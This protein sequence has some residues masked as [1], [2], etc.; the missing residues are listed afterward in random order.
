MVEFPLIRKGRG[1]ATYHTHPD[2]PRLPD[3]E[4]REGFKGDGRSATECSFCQSRR[5]EEMVDELSERLEL[6][7]QDDVLKNEGNH[8]AISDTPHPYSIGLPEISDEPVE[9]EVDSDTMGSLKGDT[10]CRVE[11]QEHTHYFKKE[12]IDAGVDVIGE[13]KLRMRD[14]SDWGFP[15]RF[16]LPDNRSLLI[17]PHMKEQNK[18]KG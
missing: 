12:W 16:L 18:P 11:G 14:D 10:L 4:N 15:C 5:T 7:E 1:A 8:V 6:S 13:D 9:V 17:A 2:C 3:P